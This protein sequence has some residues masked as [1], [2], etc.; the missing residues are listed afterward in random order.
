M[1]LIQALKT[2]FLYPSYRLSKKFPLVG[3]H[4]P[5]A[6]PLPPMSFIHRS[7]SPQGAIL[8]RFSD[9]LSITIASNGGVYTAIRQET[10]PD[11]L[12]WRLELV[13][14]PSLKAGVSVPTLQERNF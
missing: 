5:G 10:Y 14:L 3:V 13:K 4:L 9:S 12:G 8:R 2:A 7:G 6:C 1:A 11:V